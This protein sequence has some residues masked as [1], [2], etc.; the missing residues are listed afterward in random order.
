MNLEVVN[1]VQE[2]ISQAYTAKTI[3]KARQIERKRAPKT[4][5]RRGV[6]SSHDEEI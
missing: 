1:H 2:G 5:D 4:L 3:G 6:A